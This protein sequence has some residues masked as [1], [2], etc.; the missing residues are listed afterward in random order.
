MGVALEGM[1]RRGDGPMVVPSAPMSRLGRSPSS[2]L[3]LHNRKQ[4][5][6]YF[7]GQAATDKCTPNARINRWIVSHL[8]CTLPF[9]T[10]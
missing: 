3:D 6:V 9:I 8:G 10:L 4:Q 1:K 5:R 2:M 7:V